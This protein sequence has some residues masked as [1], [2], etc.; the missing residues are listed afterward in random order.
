LVATDGEFRRMVIA[1]FAEHVTPDDLRAIYRETNA[2]AEEMAELERE[3]VEDVPIPGP[4]HYPGPDAPPGT[5][6]F[7]TVPHN[8]YI[9]KMMAPEDPARRAFW[10]AIERADYSS[11][12][13]E[14]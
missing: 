1:H 4:M 2:T 14:K 13:D 6:A 10:E 11:L 5:L 8:Y 7:A 12:F 3:L 9:I